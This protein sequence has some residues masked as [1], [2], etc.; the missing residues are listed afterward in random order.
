MSNRAFSS[1]LAIAPVMV[2]LSLAPPAAAGQAPAAAK[3]WDPPRTADGKPD[4]Q[5]LWQPGLGG[6]YSIEDTGFQ[7]IQQFGAVP[8]RRGP[9]RIVDPADGT[10]PYQP[11]ARAKQQ[12][13][14]DNH[15]NPKPEHLDPVSRCF[16]GGVPRE[17]YR[18][19][20]FQILQSPGYVVIQYENGHAYRV[21]PVDGRPHITEKIRL[22]MGDSRGRWEGNTLVVDNTN[23]NGKVWY[24]IV[25]N[26]QSDASHVVERFTRIASDKINY[27]ATIEDPKIYTRPWKMAVP[28]VRVKDEG[29]ELIEEACIEGNRDVEHLLRH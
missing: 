16:L 24:D 9:S 5:G 10:I 27:E 28:L 13:I 6:S 29:Y 25:G 7:A 18:L 21:I 23:F 2:V 19:T 22:W 26:F 8:V 11:W 3:S 12:D 17:F 14:F 4:L 20:A 15:L 1:L